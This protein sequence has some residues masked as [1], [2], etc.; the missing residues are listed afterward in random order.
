MA[1][2]SLCMTEVWRETDR[3]GYQ[4]SNL[5]RVRSKRQILNPIPD[6]YG[7]LYGRT[8]DL[9]KYFVHRLVAFAFHGPSPSPQ[10]QVAHLDG[11][12]QNNR[13]DNLCWA[14]PAENAAHR[15]L[16]GRQ[17]R[18]S[19]HPCAKLADDDVRFIRDGGL[20]TG[21]LVARYGLDRSTV[22]RI[23]RGQTWKHLA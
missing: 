17:L 7:Y 1:Q 11:N 16:H 20:S 13:A 19:D 9:R 6:C 22:K 14:T 5:G 18:G 12:K 23:R 15:I 8:G 21:E 2:E 4:V 3:Q 10:H